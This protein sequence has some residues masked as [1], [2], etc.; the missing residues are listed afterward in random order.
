MTATI[1]PVNADE[2]RSVNLADEYEDK[3]TEFADRAPFGERAIAYAI[4]AVKASI[5]AH[6]ET[7]NRELPDI[8]AAIMEAGQD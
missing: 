1:P 7:L 2:I 4:L 5:D 8:G 6:R 3:A